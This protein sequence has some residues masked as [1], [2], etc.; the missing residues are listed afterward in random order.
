M[1]VGGAPENGQ[2]VIGLNA[3]IVAIIEEQPKVLVVQHTPETLTAQHET[4]T[5]RALPHDDRHEALPFGPF[6]PLKHRTLESG[7]RSW[8]EEQTNH[9]IGYVEQLY[10]FGNAGRDPREGA[11]GPRVVS[12]GYLAL[13]QD[14]GPTA[15]ENAI[16]HN[17]YHYFPW[18]DWRDGTPRILEKNIIPALRTW[19]AGSETRE[20]REERYERACITF[21]LDETPWSDELVLERYELLYEANLVKESQDGKSKPLPVDYRGTPMALDHR[22]I[23]ATAIGRLRGKIKYRPVVFELMPPTFTLLQL[24]R[25]V[26]ALSGTRL[27]KQNF[28]RL[29][30][31][32]GLVEDTGKIESQTGG[33]PA[34]Q[35]RFRREVLMERQALGV[36][37]N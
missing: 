3:V 16:W 29:I 11:G 34:S 19:I 21:G 27:H 17:W 13:V 14:T 9:E 37:H 23:L 10:T 15:I 32:K 22:R 28:R 4:L 12:V 30:E 35:F 36:R 18:E 6:Y 25:V 31:K 24:Q 20:Q 26:E 2:V 7:L 1:N 5:D 33:R 8:V